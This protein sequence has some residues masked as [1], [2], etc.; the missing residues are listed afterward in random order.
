MAR[1]PGLTAE[2]TLL[3]VTTLSFDIAALELSLPLCVGG[4][5]VIATRDVTADGGKL[6][7]LLASSG[8]TVMQATPATWRLLLE[9][10]WAGPAPRKVLCGGEALPRDLAEALLARAAEVWNM[11]GPT[12]TTV[13]SAAGPV[14]AGPGPVTVG[15]PIANTELYVLG[16]Q[17]QVVPVGVAGELHIG[18]EGVAAGYWNRP[19][20]T[21]EK[22]VPDPFRPG[23]G[24]RLYKTGDLVRRLP[25]GSLEFL[26][27]LDTQVKVRGF[28]IETA[29][30]EHALKQYPGVRECVV[31]A[32]E[33]TPGDKR[34]VA[35]LAAAAAPA[36][37][38][39]RSFLSAK[40][41]AYMVPSLFV[42]L[43]ALPRTPNGKID[44]RSLPAPA[45]NGAG[46]KQ[47]VVAPRNPR[48]KKLADICADVLRLEAFS[49]HDSL[50]DL[51]ADSI[52]VFQIVARAA[53]AGLDLAPKHVLAG[54]S[55][56]A[57][58]E[59]LERDGRSAPRPEAPAL[60]AVSRDR[61]RMQRSQLNAH[62]RA[63]G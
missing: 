63:N 18:G 12:E 56:A 2:D 24:R 7:A 37:A 14:A 53:D 33:D 27:R 26:G 42:P 31:V 16:P 61:Y 62:D 29:D 17:G 52:Q 28:R 25:G 47:D 15:P 10:G 60:T 57:I 58:C 46:R 49:V 30:V 40:L 51:G 38:D 21:A 9:A 44:R 54:R 8:A 59:E 20:L 39:L 13:W 6:L 55:V 22:F 36:A 19:E 45:A 48:E 43:E 1:Q 4:R 41:P 11:Y 32:R 23:P 50:F 5:V 3:A 35:Y 34:L